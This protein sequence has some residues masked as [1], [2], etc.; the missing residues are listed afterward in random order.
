MFKLR[1]P[2]R[3]SFLFLL[4]IFVNVLVVGCEDVDL[5]NVGAAVKAGVAALPA[6]AASIPV[7]DPYSAA[8]KIGLGVLSVVLTVFAAKKENDVKIEKNKNAAITEALTA[9]IKEGPNSGIID[10]A[11]L[12][13]TLRATVRGG[14]ASL[15]VKGL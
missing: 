4:L 11:V 13:N 15:N 10:V 5:E 6:I 14:L 8:I 12:R 7:V 3:N 2:M 1:S 9:G